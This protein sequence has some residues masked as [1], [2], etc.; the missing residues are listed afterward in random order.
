MEAVT[1]VTVQKAKK[2]ARRSYLHVIDNWER[3][4]YDCNACLEA[5]NYY[6]AP[7]MKT[8]PDAT[9]ACFCPHRACPYREEF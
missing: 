5:L 4:H 1:I 3:K 9:D 8:D 2:R 7:M 6:G